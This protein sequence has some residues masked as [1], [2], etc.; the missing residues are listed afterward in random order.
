MAEVTKEQEIEQAKKIRDVTK[1][2]KTINEIIKRY[3]KESKVP[4]DNNPK[5]KPRQG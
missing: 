5:D 3:G 2:L 1:R 4:P